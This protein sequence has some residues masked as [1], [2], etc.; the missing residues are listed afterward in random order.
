MS[1]YIH[2]IPGRLRVRSPFLKGDAEIAQAVVER[3]GRVPGVKAVSANPVTGSVVAE[4]DP[5]RVEAH[6]LVAALEAEGHF[7]RR[8]AITNDQ[9]IHNAVAGAVNV[10]KGSLLGGA[11]DFA[12]EGTSL[13]F[14]SVLI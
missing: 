11:L 9:Y 3:L 1:Y 4:Y 13:A 6:A 2:D 7:D 14:L 12:L 5:A 10:V 8:R